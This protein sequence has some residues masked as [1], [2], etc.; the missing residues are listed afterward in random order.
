MFPKASSFI[1]SE[2]IQSKQSFELQLQFLKKFA[3]E[4]SASLLQKREVRVHVNGT[5]AAFM[6]VGENHQ[7]RTF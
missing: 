3:Q 1:E 5:V 6:V 4:S 7:R 2:G